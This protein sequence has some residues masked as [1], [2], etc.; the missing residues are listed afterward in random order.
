V[1]YS[2]KAKTSDSWEFKVNDD[3]KRCKAYITKVYFAD[4][5][6]WTP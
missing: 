2:L 4:G 3:A 6:T 5:T 1:N